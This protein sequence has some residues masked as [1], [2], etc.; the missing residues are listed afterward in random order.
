MDENKYNSLNVAVTVGINSIESQRNQS[1]IIVINVKYNSNII[2][3]IKQINKKINNYKYQSIGLYFASTFN[4]INKYKFIKEFNKKKI[5]ITIGSL[6]VTKSYFKIFDYDTEMT[7][8][9]P[10]HITPMY[11]LNY[12]KE[13]KVYG[14]ISIKYDDNT[15]YNN[16]LS[17]KLLDIK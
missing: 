1:S 17:S 5:D 14:Y 16:I 12:I 11:S 9:N 6:P 10:Y 8:Y 3:F 4:N 2:Y 15:L 13:K 7:V